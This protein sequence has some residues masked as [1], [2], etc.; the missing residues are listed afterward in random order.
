MRR[1]AQALV[2]P[3]LT[4]LFE[5]ARCRQQKRYRNCAIA[6]N[7]RSVAHQKRSHADA[8]AKATHS[9]ENF[10]MVQTR[11]DADGCS[12]MKQCRRIANTHSDEAHTQL[13]TQTIS[14]ATCT[15]AH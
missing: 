15:P 14:I 1:E 12:I 5:I 9:R 11:W 3:P 8:F 7:A 10:Q 2:W 13:G 6:Y 4:Q